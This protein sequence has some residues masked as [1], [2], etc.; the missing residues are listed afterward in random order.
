M[1]VAINKDAHAAIFS[2][3]D[4]IIVEDLTTFLPILIE[5]YNER[6]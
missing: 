6:N 2:I 3:A 5:K 4:Y 1:I